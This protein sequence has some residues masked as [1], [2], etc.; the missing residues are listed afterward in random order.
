MR[1][2]NDSYQCPQ[3]GTAGVYDSVTGL[4]VSHRNNSGDICVDELGAYHVKGRVSGKSNLEN[5]LTLEEWKRLYIPGRVVPISNSQLYFQ[6]SKP[7]VRKNFWNKEDPTPWMVTGHQIGN[8]S[9]K[10]WREAMDYALFRPM[11]MNYPA[12]GA[13]VWSM[14]S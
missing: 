5:A 13:P 11:M 7:R 9:F 6:S 4:V 8:Q 1:Y 12:D 10:T 2:S 3:C 14:N